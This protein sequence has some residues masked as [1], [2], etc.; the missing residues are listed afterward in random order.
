MP[1]PGFF[2]GSEMTEKR[3][4]E[5]TVRMS[6]TLKHDLMDEAA[7]HDR[8]LSEV[9]RIILE[10]YLY[11]QKIRTDEACGRSNPRPAL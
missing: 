4:S 9:I 8:T 6:E 7:A 2:L 3:I 1:V 10:G 5:V 11:G